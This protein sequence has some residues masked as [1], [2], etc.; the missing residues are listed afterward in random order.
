MELQAVNRIL[1]SLKT[2]N[3]YQKSFPL[4]LG[5]QLNPVF[6]SAKLQIAQNW[7]SIS[8]LKQGVVSLT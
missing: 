5:Q 3:K 7:H 8:N 1:P 4:V 6:E 2:L